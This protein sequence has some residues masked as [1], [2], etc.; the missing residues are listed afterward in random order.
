MKRHGT[1]PCRNIIFAYFLVDKCKEGKQTDAMKTRKGIFFTE[2]DE[3]DR[4]RI[5]KNEDLYPSPELK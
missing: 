2:L 5:V 1:G 4:Q 3:K